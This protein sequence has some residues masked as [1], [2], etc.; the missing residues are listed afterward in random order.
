MTVTFDVWTI[1]ARRLPATLALVAGRRVPGARFAKILGTGD[2][3]TFSPWHATPRRWAVL[4]VWDGE[5]RRPSRWERL[6]AER[7]HARLAPLSARGSWS[8][9]HPFGSPPGD[10]A[11]DGPVA[12]LTRA[13]L[14]LARARSF[15]RAVPPVAADLPG[16]AG[17]RL[18]LA[19][20]EAPVGLQGTFSVWE[21][22]AALRAFA[23]DRAAHADVV[24]R[25][26]PER[27]YAE[28]L[29]ARF[30]VV[31][32]HGTVDGVDPLR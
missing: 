13:R 10:P 30:A 29:F 28:E 18:A 4:A 17:L 9:Q 6:A 26:G 3:A 32:A 24:R 7:W 14:R 19:V 8:R 16:S 21:S 27:W 1:P 5:P 12:A 2:P 15:R 11:Y 31:E 22:P 25:A 20:G 23:Y